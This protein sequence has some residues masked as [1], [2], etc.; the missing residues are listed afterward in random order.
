ML[1]AKYF[2]H[3]SFLAATVPHNASFIWKSICESKEVL[4]QGLR[5]R[6]GTREHIWIWK[7]QWLPSS[8]S[9]RVISP[10]N[11]LDEFAT[12]DQLINQDSMTWK[13]Q[14]LHEIFCPRDVDLIIC[15]PLSVRRPPDSLIWTGTKRGV[16][17][18]KSA[19]HLQL[20][21]H[22]SQEA[23]TSSRSSVHSIWSS[24]WAVKVPPKVKLFVW[25][26]C[27]DILPTR[28]KLFE[29]G[30]SHSYSCLWCAEEPETCD[31]VLWGC[32]F[33]QKVWKSSFVA[34]SSQYSLCLHFKDFIGT[35]I[36]ELP[37]PALE[38]AFTTAWALWKARNETCWEGKI[39]VVD[40]ICQEVACIALDFLEANSKV[41]GDTAGLGG[42]SRWQKPP[43]GAV[44]LN[45]ACCFS[46]NA[47]KV[48]VGLL[49]RDTGGIV[50]AV[51]EDSF[52]ACGDLLQSHARAVLKAVQF[53]FDV[54]FR[55]LVVE[56]DNLELCN[57]LQAG[58]PCL[59]PIGV[60]VEDICSWAPCFNMLSFVF[61]KKICNK[62]AHA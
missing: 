22:N 9:F 58:L 19:Y 10:V 49:I 57:L 21:L 5:W 26:A 13:V 51:L 36:L 20:S 7:D 43:S 48:E 4:G 56:M 25:K 1:K 8:T 50:M 60:L 40:A 44:K 28:M 6:V 33:A 32:E 23:A 30:I 52:Q 37:S 18:V 39:P 14:L 12:V 45:L 15:I 38:I 59:A 17:S 54:G 47:A 31:H 2:P 16:F 24:I 55:R 34:I 62:A 27:H 46:L 35:L 29:K 53:A 61:S 3:T 11:V 41:L 42:S